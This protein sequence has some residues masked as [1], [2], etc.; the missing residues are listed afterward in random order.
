MIKDKLNEK[1]QQVVSETPSQWHEDARF[2]MKNKKWIKR[3]QVIALRILSTIR[4]NGWNQK[5]LAE[6]IGVSPQTINKW[7]KGRE[8]FTL[9]TISKLEDA[10]QIELLQIV[11]KA[12]EVN[13]SHTINV[14]VSQNKGNFEITMNKSLFEAKIIPLIPAYDTWSNHTSKAI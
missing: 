8:N 9:E 6:K 10:L 11:G 1:L 12:N 13:K 2:R 3:S 5:Q 7:V 4:E 14:P